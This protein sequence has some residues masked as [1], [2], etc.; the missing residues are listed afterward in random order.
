NLGLLQIESGR[1]ADGMATLG[2]VL[3][4]DPAYP[5]AHL[6]RGQAHMMARRFA[7]A[8]PDLQEAVRLR[9]ESA[10]ALWLLG[11]A[12][13][14]LGHEREARDALCRAAALGHARAAEQCK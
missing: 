4:R 8:L 10:D 9:P 12:H 2:Q 5:G 3:E 14:R 1:V 7:Q 13:A 6:A 11:H